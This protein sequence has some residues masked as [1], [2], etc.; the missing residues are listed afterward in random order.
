MMGSASTPGRIAGWAFVLILLVAAALLFLLVWLSVAPTSTF[1]ALIGIGW[2]ALLF[3]LIAYLAQAFS[4][5]PLVGR[6][7]GI[8]FA[9]MGFT[10]IGVTAGLFPDASVTS[11]T[12][13]LL[14][15]AML[16]FLAIAVV[17][18]SWGARNRASVAQREA[19]RDGWR[20]QPPTSAFDYA[21]A[22][23]PSVPRPSSPSA[24]SSAPTPPPSPPPGG[25]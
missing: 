17:G 8:G 5:N 18:V 20:A 3:A 16:V 14:A 13:I 25:H 4:R 19:A 12:R 2:L 22:Q 23:H 24:P 21:S 15:L 7:T 10:V 11:T 9:A 1:W 6:A